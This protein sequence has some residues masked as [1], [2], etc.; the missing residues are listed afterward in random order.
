MI[1]G[2]KVYV[3]IFVIT[4]LCSCISSLYNNVSRGYDL[5]RNETSKAWGS[6][7]ISYE[8]YD[9]LY[10]KEMEKLNN[11]KASEKIRRLTLSNIPIGGY[12]FIYIKRPIMQTANTNNFQYILFENEQEILREKGRDRVAETPGNDQ[13]WWNV[14]RIGLD[15]PIENSLTLH[16][17]DNL[18]K[19]AFTIKKKAAVIKK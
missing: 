9:D 7:A 5:Q 18:G 1:R 14:D 19:D 8:D 15:H 3:S 11:N 13:L 12:I 16:V 10:Q 2:L 4:L 6:V 17:V